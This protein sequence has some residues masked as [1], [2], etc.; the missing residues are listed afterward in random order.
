MHTGQL[1]DLQAVL[2][3]YSS[4][5]PLAQ[6]GYDPNALIT[7]LQ[8]L[9]AEAAGGLQAPAFLRS[10]PATSERIRDVSFLIRQ[11]GSLSGLRS[12]DGKLGIIQDRI[13]LVA[14]TD[15]DSESESE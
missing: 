14:G 9:Q 2:D 7:M 10:H 3:H 6:A 11:Q 15:V 4:D 5:P 12:D 8:T 1:P 13:R